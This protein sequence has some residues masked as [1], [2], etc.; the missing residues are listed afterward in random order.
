MSSVITEPETIALAEVDQHQFNRAVWDRLSQDPV[1]VDLDYRIET[2]RHGQVIMS[3]PPAPAQGNFQ[4]EIVWHLKSL[5]QNGKVITECPISTQE[6]VKAA[7]V[8][9]CSDPVWD[10]LGDARFFVQC[11]EIVIEILSPS[12][13]KGEIK[14][15]IE[16]YFAGGAEEVW[17]CDNRGGMKFLIDSEERASSK[18]FPDFPQNI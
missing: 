10:S 1:W 3:S 2:D 17:I 8:A 6:G 14:E 15:K 18:R 4:S 13:T 12:N 16:L 11:P 5:S 9:W 7:D